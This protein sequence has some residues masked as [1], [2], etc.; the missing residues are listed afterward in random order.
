MESCLTH[1]SAVDKLEINSGSNN[2]AEE[3][4]RRLGVQAAQFSSAYE[5][6]ACEW[7]IY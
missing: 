7:F 4:E 3:L 2:A 5:Q 1:T 6:V